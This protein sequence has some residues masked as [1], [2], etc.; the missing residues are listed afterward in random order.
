[1]IVPVVIRTNIFPDLY[2]LYKFF[3]EY[4]VMDALEHE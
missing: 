3:L 1:M 2:F 4:I